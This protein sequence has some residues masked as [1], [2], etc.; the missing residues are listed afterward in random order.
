[1]NW[2]LLLY[3]TLLVIVVIDALASTFAAAYLYRFRHRFGT[4]L[5]KAFLACAL[6]SWAA[7]ITSGFSPAPRQII[8]WAVSLR[9]LTRIYKTWRMSMLAAFLLGWVN[10]D[11]SEAMK[12]DPK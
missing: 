4:Y 8:V 7:I 1:M 9:I 10:G 2:L 12:N 5:A 11:H 3:N 6:E